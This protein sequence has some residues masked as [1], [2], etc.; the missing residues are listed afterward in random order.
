MFNSHSGH[1]QV[2]FGIYSSDIQKDSNHYLVKFKS[3][4]GYIQVNFVLHSSHIQIME[5]IINKI[6]NPPHN[7]DSLRYN[8]TILQYYNIT[9]LQYY[10]ITM[11]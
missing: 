10:N 8:I 1:I 3:I 5:G 2:T 4:L 7:F 9:I 11:L 6:A